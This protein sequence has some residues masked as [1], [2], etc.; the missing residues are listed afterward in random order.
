[1]RLVGG[2]VLFLLG[3]AAST[4]DLPGQLPIERLREY[5]G[6]IVVLNFWAAWCKPCKKEMPLLME[7]QREYEGRGVQFLGACTDESQH[8]QEAEEFLRTNAIT[9]PVWF[10]FSDEEMKPL[11][12][13]SSIPA[14][15]IF[16]R[17]GRRVFRLIG[18]VKRKNVVERLEWLLGKQEGR[19]PKEL[20]LP[21]G[22]D[23]AEY[24][25]R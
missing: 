4:T 22:L 2:L 3:I 17:E 25:K 14:T 12:L 20:L 5:R 21:P 19:P 15:A 13:G 6:K 9:Y 23:R 10:G 7:L 24:E 11:G 1:M 16:D 8:R 18:E